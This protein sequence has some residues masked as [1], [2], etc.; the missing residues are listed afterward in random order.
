MGEWCL[1]SKTSSGL[2]LKS[3]PA[4]A[5]I[6]KAPKERSKLWLKLAKRTGLTF[7]LS[8]Y[9]PFSVHVLLCTP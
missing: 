2:Q 5:V 8:V 7:S 3:V 9:V 1:G 4:N 6:Q